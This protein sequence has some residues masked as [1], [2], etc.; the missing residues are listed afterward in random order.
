M[1]SA[2]KELAQEL[3]SYMPTYSSAPLTRVNYLMCGGQRKWAQYTRRVQWVRQ[4]TIALLASVEFLASFLNIYCVHIYVL[5]LIVTRPSLPLFMDF[6]RSILVRHS[7]Y[8]PYKTCWRSVIPL[9]H[10]RMSL[11]WIFPRPLTRCLTHTSWASSGSLVSKGTSPNG[12]KLSSASK[13]R[14]CVDGHLSTKADVKSGVPQRTILGALLFLGLLNDLPSVV[15][16]DT[17]VRLFVDDCLIYRSISSTSWNSRRTCTA[18][19]HG[20][21]SGECALKQTSATS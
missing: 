5:I 16:A 17:Q 6:G 11:F 1:P 21:C 7:F 10:R 8:S 13:H 4:W 18:W 19:Q 3:S 12:S 9:S 2:V 15:H 14:V 20:H